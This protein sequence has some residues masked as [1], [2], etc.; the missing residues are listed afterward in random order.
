MSRLPDVFCTSSFFVK[1]LGQLPSVF[2][3]GEFRLPGDAYTGDSRLYGDEYTE[4]SPLPNGE[5]TGESIT[6]TNNFWNIK[7][8]IEILPMRV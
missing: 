1:K 6:N 4:E 7:K 2:I 5:Y 8:K 3:T